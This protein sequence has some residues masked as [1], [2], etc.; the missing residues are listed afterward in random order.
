MWQNFPTYLLNGAHTH[1]KSKNLKPLRCDCIFMV[2]VLLAQWFIDFYSLCLFQ[3]EVTYRVCPL[4]L[5]NCDCAKVF[6]HSLG[7]TKWNLSLCIGRV[8]RPGLR[9]SSFLWCRTLP[10]SF[11]WNS[12]LGPWC[13]SLPE[14][15]VRCEN[16]LS[17][18]SRRV[19]S[20]VCC[21]VV[22]TLPVGLWAATSHSQTQYTDG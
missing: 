1:I 22:S 20:T 10:P 15:T 19:Y 16:S 4:S 21:G 17:D 9:C 14:S 3:Y 5:W 11:S 8:W 13:T 7:L 18:W 12:A 2:T 6:C